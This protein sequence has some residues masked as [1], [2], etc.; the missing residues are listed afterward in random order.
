MAP[1]P[2]DAFVTKL[3]RDGS[4]VVYSTFLG[5]SYRDY[6]NA[7]AVDA[8]GNAYVAG[9]TWSTDFPTAGPQQAALNARPLYQSLD[10]GASFNAAA[11]G[12][13][14]ANVTSIL[15]EPTNSQKVYV[16]TSDAGIFASTDGGGA[17][18]PSSGGGR[19]RNQLSDFDAES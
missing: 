8:A 1:R 15:V 3:S 17:W 9:E 11:T 7:I 14:G 4:Q 18:N 13:T 5:G 19:F 10:G 6:G 12:M 16:A 2:P